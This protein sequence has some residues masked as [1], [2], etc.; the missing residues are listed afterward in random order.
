MLM[1][2]QVVLVQAKEFARRVVSESGESLEKRVDRAWQIA[3]GDVPNVA[4]RDAALEFLQNQP[5]FLQ[6]RTPPI[7]NAITNPKKQLRPR[8][9]RSAAYAWC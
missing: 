7:H 3:Y 8:N 6:N 1:N 5:D 9:R 4:E 2:S